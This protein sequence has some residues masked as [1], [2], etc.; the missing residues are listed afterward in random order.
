[1]WNELLKEG[2]PMANHYIY[3]DD[4]KHDCLGM[5][6]DDGLIYDSRAFFDGYTPDMSHC[7]GC[8][9]S[10]GYV[11]S[12][13][14]KRDKIGMIDHE[15][16]VYR[17]YGFF[18]GSAPSGTSPLGYVD[19]DGKVYDKVSVFTNTAPSSFPVAWVESGSNRRT[20]GA[21]VLLL[22][23]VSSASATANYSSSGRS[24]GGSDDSWEGVTIVFVLLLAVV[25]M[26][27]FRYW[28]Y[29]L[30]AGVALVAEIIILCTMLARKRIKLHELFH[31]KLLLF[32]AIAAVISTFAIQFIMVAVVFLFSIF[33]GS[34][35]VNNKMDAIAFEYSLASDLALAAGFLWPYVSGE[36]LSTLFKKN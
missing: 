25:A 20:V 1:M 12:D 10:S 31:W 5:Y 23:L 9:D 30:V 7:V 24:T 2:T 26:F 13:I 16:K 36:N 35:A 27:W 21:A 34:T 8:I 4:W 3:K 14:R 6:T 32:G 22:G 15:G 18:D 28:T 33:G 19:D 29:A 17:G 11:Y